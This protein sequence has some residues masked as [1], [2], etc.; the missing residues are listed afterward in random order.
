M[1]LPLNGWKL[2]S[3]EAALSG[4]DARGA[5]IAYKQSESDLWS[6]PGSWGWLHNSKEPFCYL[7]QSESDVVA[8]DI[9]GTNSGNRVAAMAG[10]PSGRKNKAFR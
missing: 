7:N 1:Q 5:T 3:G 10:G 8:G 2:G 6:P 4:T 9:P